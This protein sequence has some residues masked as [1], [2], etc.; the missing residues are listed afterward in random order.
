MQPGA[1]PEGFDNLD[2]G[3]HRVENQNRTIY[4]RGI[5]HTGNPQ[6]EGSLNPFGTPTL[7]WPRTFADFGGF[8][9]AAIGGHVV[10]NWIRHLLPE[11][12]VSC[13]LEDENFDDFV[14]PMQVSR[15]DPPADALIPWGHEDS[16]V[17]TP[18][19]NTRDRGIRIHGI[20]SIPPSPPTVR[21][22]IYLAAQGFGDTLFGDVRRLI[23]G[24][25]Q[26]FSVLPTSE[27]SATLARRVRPAGALTQHIGRPATALHLRPVGIDAF[28]CDKHVVSNPFNCDLLIL[29]AVTIPS[30]QYIGAPR[31]IQR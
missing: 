15:R 17:G 26:T 11:G 2:V 12:W 23:P 1:A 27:P 24:T 16:A 13:S 6:L 20:G 3:G 19:L 29:P 10:Q 4:P 22:R 9:S 31:V 14:R 21:G 28:A 8:D 7:G 25:I 5:S 18:S 30:P